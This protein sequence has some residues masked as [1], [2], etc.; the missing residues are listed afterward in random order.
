MIVIDN[1]IKDKKY[2]KEL[3]S[4]KNKFFDDLYDSNNY[5]HDVNWWNG[6]W[7]DEPKNINQ[8]L[9]EYIAK[10]LNKSNL[11]DIE[12]VKGFEYWT[13]VHSTE[14]S[15]D[16]DKKSISVGR[17]LGWHTNK[18]EILHREKEEFKHPLFSI[19][20]WPFEQNVDGGYLEMSPIR[21]EDEKINMTG[22][23]HCVECSKEKLPFDVERIKPKYNRLV[24]QDPSYWHRVTHVEGGTRWTFVID[25]W[26]TEII[27][28][29]KMER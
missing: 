3:T 5:A 12:K 15:I 6:W 18:D 8:E 20:F 29:N 26:G 25:V 27:M 24:V 7:V 17:H 1:F 4:K 19:I 22:Y 13:H 10:E 28:N 23:P 21:Q 16:I 14:P 2:L 11:I 9:I